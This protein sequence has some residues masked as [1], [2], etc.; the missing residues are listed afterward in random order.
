MDLERG[1][2]L[3]GRVLLHLQGPQ[4]GGEMIEQLSDNQQTNLAGNASPR[5]GLV[6]NRSK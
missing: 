6:S 5:V 3:L 2:L 1:R 4:F